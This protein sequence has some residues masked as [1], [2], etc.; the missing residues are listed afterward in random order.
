[1]CRELYAIIT[2]RSNN[3]SHCGFSN[4]CIRVSSKAP[5][6]DRISLLLVVVFAKRQR[7]AWRESY[8]ASPGRHGSIGRGF[9]VVHSGFA[10][11][12]AEMCLMRRNA[13]VVFSGESEA[14]EWERDCSCL[15]QVIES[16]SDPED[17]DP[18]ERP[19]GEFAER[20]SVTGNLL[21]V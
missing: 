7:G 1:M 5:E 4:G 6:V 19:V 8:L 2:G 9:G 13:V 10:Q 11:L 21:T 20:E 18:H 14:T 16:V 12:S 17:A 3:H 15:G